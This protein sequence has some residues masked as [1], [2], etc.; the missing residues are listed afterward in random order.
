MKCIA[1]GSINLIEGAI[2]DN[3]GSTREFFV[4]HYVS[5]IKATFGIGT[6]DVTAYGCVHCGNLQFTV[7]FNEADKQHYLQFEGQQPDL[8]KRLEDES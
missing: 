3:A 6:K 7:Q 5:S 4:P 1:C 8:L 2:S